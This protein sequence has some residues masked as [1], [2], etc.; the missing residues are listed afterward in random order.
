[1]LEDQVVEPLQKNSFVN[2]QN[3]QVNYTSFLNHGNLSMNWKY[4]TSLLY[5]KRKKLL[6]LLGGLDCKNKTI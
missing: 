4:Y 2:F 6:K 1:M 3:Y 5:F